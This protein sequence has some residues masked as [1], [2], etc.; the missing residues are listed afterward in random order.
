MVATRPVFHWTPQR[1]RGHF[2]LCFLA[3]LLERNLEI[4]LRDNH[5]ELSPDKIKEV[6]NSLKLS[7]VRINDEEYF[8]KAKPRQ[9]AATILRAF[10][11]KAPEN[12]TPVS[13]FSMK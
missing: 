12:L 9:P 11:I 3:F 13:Q 8:L 10:R 1:I 5:I 4:R 2:T 7:R 6:L